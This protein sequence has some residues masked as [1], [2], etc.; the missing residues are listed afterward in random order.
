MDGFDLILRGGR[1]VLPWGL[2]E[3]DVG[4]RAGRIAAI[5]DLRTAGAAQEIDCRGLTVLPGVIDPHVHLRDPG[6]PAVET[7][8]DGTRGA[9][10]GG[11]TCLFDMP[12]TAEPITTSERLAKKR[13]LLKG[14]AWC[15][16]GLYVAASKANIPALGALEAEPG[17]CAIKVFTAATTPELLV[18]DDASLEALMRA[19]RRTV[20]YHS[21]DHA[22]LSAR[23]ALYQ[24]GDNPRHHM[25]WHDVE[26]CLLGTQRITRLARK[27][28]RPAHILHVSTAEELDWLADYRDVASAEVLVNHLT[29]TGPEIYDRLG[30]YAVMSPPIRERRHY[31][32][33]WAAV[34]DG[35]VDCI[36]SDHAPHSRAAKERPW[37]QTA[38]GLTGTQTLLPIM[39]DHVSAGRLSFSRLADLTSAGPA[40][41]YGVPTK[42][43]LAVGFDA[44]FSIVD[45]AHERTIEEK[46]IASPC[47]WSP[48]VGTRCKGWPRATVVGGHV[49]MREDEVL[50]TPIGG[51]VRFR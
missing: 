37:P 47:G 30:T 29:Q 13:D 49:V 23:K 25:D 2:E 34:R 10:L 26:C 38:S 11:V 14:R 48:F 36:G 39:L 42:G 31:E 7:I 35:R 4:V 46:W 40:R 18:D 6:D 21:E 12:N 20:A 43:R 1:L 33:A 22:R 24:P 15:N 50:G 27:T 41:I 17:V 45:P 5:G 32:A 44:D 3:A 19:G 9:V 8:P 28:G 16:V 51:G